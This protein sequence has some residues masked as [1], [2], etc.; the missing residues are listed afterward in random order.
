MARVAF[1]DKHSTGASSVSYR[2]NF[3]DLFQSVE[4]FIVFWN[5]SCH[6]PLTMLPQQTDIMTVC[7]V[8]T[9]FLK[10]HLVSSDDYFS[11]RIKHRIIHIWPVI[12][13]IY[14][15]SSIRFTKIFVYPKV[16]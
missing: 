5:S 7:H 3:L 11:E 14:C 13:G 4:E 16:D 15:L 2:H 10:S 6:R 9:V 1:G 8:E 12:P